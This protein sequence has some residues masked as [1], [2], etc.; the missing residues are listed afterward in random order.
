M[1]SNLAGNLDLVCSL[2]DL[3]WSKTSSYI[4]CMITKCI[5]IM[6]LPGFHELLHLLACPL[7]IVQILDYSIVPRRGS[8]VSVLLV[9]QKINP[10]RFGWKTEEGLEYFLDNK[11]H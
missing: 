3:R 5:K 4:F 10:L 11:Q 6:A 9:R 1:L 7:T 2:A 8:Q